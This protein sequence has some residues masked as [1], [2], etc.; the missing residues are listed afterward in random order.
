MLLINLKKRLELK[1][2]ERLFKMINGLSPIIR[3]GTTGDYKPFSFY[4]Q[5]TNEFTG[6]DIKLIKTSWLKL[7][8]D[9]IY[10]KLL[11]ISFSINA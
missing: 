1:V 2:V 8:N 10:N 5:D 4:N 9:L 11:K 3:V 7:E 6:F